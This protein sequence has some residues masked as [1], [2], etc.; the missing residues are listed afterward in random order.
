MS[1]ENLDLVIAGVRA[2]L[3][4]PPDFK[5]VNRVYATDHVFVPL[6]AG[7]LLDEAQ[8]AEGFRTWL[9][10]TTE[11]LDLEHELRGAVDLDPD[12]V[13]VVTTTRFTGSVS[14]V[15][16][17]QRSWAVVTVAKG[18]IGRTEAFGTAS[19]ALEAV[20]PSE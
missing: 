13:L 18:K 9:A 20:G 19:E 11:A 15:I 4:R 12:Q 10:E 14:G 7:V 3:A 17:E 8:G 16:S 6:A 2:A 1:Q 5:T